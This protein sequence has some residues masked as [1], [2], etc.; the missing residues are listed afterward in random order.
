MKKKND[1]I[2]SYNF[3][4]YFP[5]GGETMEDKTI[6]RRSGPDPLVKLIGS[7]TSFSWMLLFVIAVFSWILISSI[8]I[9]AHVTKAPFE[10]FV[11][12]RYHF[13]LSESRHTTLI[14]DSFYL[15]IFIFILSCA[16]LVLNS[17]RHNRK[18]DTYSR[19]LIIFAV[20]SLMGI[21]VHLMLL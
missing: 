21:I 20:L 2:M 3:F 17:F 12:Q 1:S 7:I 19:P 4:K 15:M 9:V 6:N 5:M 16:G 14:A 13:T 18:N 8:F 11:E 10:G